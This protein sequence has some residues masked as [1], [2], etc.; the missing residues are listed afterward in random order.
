MA[1]DSGRAVELSEASNEPLHRTQT[2]LYSASV[3][4]H[5]KERLIGAAVLVAAAVIL[6]PEMLSGPDRVAQREVP[7]A[8]ASDAALKTYTIDLSRSPAAQVSAA[9]TPV[10]DEA[11]PPELPAPS[12]STPSAEPQANSDSTP[13]APPRAEAQQPLTSASAPAPQEAAPATATSPT[14]A[15][16]PMVQKPTS[17]SVVHESKPPTG[18]GWVVQLGSFSTQAT[19]D[20]LAK[21]FRADGY[22]AFVMP[23]KSAGNTLYRVRLG[24]VGD[25]D[26]AMRMLGRIKAKVPG[27]AVVPHP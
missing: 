15:A 10:P 8:A 26:G 20:N 18:K 12:A 21:Q 23:V 1:E 2:R 19:A 3:E 5:V 9:E 25:R 22:Q 4:R 16:R 27:A 13:A 11:P 24:P 14:P 6:I 7:A 17:P